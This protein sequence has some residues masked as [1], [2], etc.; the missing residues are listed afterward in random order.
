MR[1][2]I[3]TVMVYVA[4]LS[5]LIA[6]VVYGIGCAWRR[7]QV[8]REPSACLEAMFRHPSND[9]ASLVSEVENYLREMA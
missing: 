3:L 7:R 5:P 2:A 1:V 6:A 9:G 8:R 4:M